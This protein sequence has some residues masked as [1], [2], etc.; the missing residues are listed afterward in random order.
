MRKGVKPHAYVL[1]P[2]LLEL[3]LQ[4]VLPLPWTVLVEPHQLPIEAKGGTQ[5]E[6]GP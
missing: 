5:A 2:Y 4:R 6:F 3:L 1:G